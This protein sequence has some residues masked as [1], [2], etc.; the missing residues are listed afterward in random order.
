MRN[1]LLTLLSAAMLSCG[2]LGVSGLPLLVALVPL[3][4]VIERQDCFWHT[5]GFVALALGLWS[6]VTTWW[7][8]MVPGGW[9][10][11]VL[12]VIITV[13]LFGGVFALYWLVKRRFPQLA[14]VVLVSG[15]IA[16][17]LLYTV[18]E[19]NFPWLVLGNGFANDVKAV[20]WYEITGVFGGTLWVWA[21]NILIF[22]VLRRQ[23]RWSVAAVVVLVPL[24]VS[25]VRY[26]TYRERG[27]E[28]VAMVVQPDFFAWQKFGA[29]DEQTQIDTMLRL[30]ARAPA[31]VDI[32]VYPE[33]ALDM[34]FQED[35]LADDPVIEQFRA[36]LRQKYPGA[37]MVM[38]ATTMRFYR[39][40][41]R[42]SHTARETLHDVFYDFYNSALLI[43]TA[44][45]V[46]VHHK[47]KLV[48]GV[49]R[50]PFRGKFKLLDKLM[51]DL[52][53][54]SNNLGTDSVATVF[55]GD[56]G[57]AICWE[58]VFGEYFAEF[59][60]RG[61][62]LMTVV[63]NDSWWGDTRGYRQL[64]AFSR[65]RAVETRRAI[66]RSA[67]TGTSGFIDQRGNALA[68][69]NWNETMA[70]TATLR[71]ND[72]I[73][74]YTRWGDF[75]A[76]IATLLFGLSILYYVALLFRRR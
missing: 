76:R 52:G 32:F 16:A 12:S 55:R 3:L 14:F 10:G 56:I 34:Q 15:W 17:E 70:I 33:T 27:E 45:T 43:D 61:A 66:A 68:Q 50:M 1:F 73:T 53:G 72:R 6:G 24:A 8:A 11:A 51:V 18:G 28:R 21:C 49:E 44:S 48:V 35:H 69:T 46:E 36:L 71:T 39:P 30:S 13:V 54:T 47:T 74:P 41:E 58:A 75:V 9:P 23:T 31:D 67:N 40:G 29:V 64:F 25:L 60:G 19:L 5:M 62:T 7:I 57:A 59:V 22:N 26:Y 63:S 42:I 37:K 4:L 20:Q 38:G 2:W 65:L